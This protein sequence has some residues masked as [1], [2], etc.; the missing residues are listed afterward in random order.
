MTATQILWMLLVRVQEIFISRWHGPDAPDVV[1][2]QSARTPQEQ[3]FADE[4]PAK[5]RDGLG[6]RDRR[7]G[8]HQVGGGRG[9]RGR[10]DR[11]RDGRIG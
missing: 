1:V 5:P 2:V 6:C 11:Q 8:P 4:L 9:S 7:K 10:P 3:L